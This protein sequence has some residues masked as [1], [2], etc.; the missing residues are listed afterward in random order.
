M[1]VDLVDDFGITDGVLRFMARGIVVAEAVG[2][3]DFKRFVSGL[4]FVASNLDGNQTMTPVTVEDDGTGVP[5][6]TTPALCA[7]SVALLFRFRRATTMQ[8][9]KLI[10]ALIRRVDLHDVKR[11]IA[12]SCWLRAVGAPVNVNR[13][14]PTAGRETHPD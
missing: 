5:E 10:G 12:S 7:L 4:T 6:P 8:R 3:T 11:A 9:R 13:T 2:P 1:V 14:T